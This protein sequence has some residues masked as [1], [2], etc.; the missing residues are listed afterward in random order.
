MMKYFDN[1]NMPVLLGMLA[2]AVAILIAVF[3]LVRHLHK[4]TDGRKTERIVKKYSEAYEREVIFPD[5]IGGYFFID[6]L[7]LLQG[8]IVALNIAQ[9]KGYVF[10]GEN[11]EAWT[12]IENNKSTKFKNPLE[13]VKLFVNHAKDQLKFDGIMARVLFDSKCEFPKGVPEGVSQLAYFK[14][15]MA[16]WAGEAHAA[17]ATN[18]AW[19]TLSALL[20][21]SRERYNKEVGVS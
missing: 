4:T 18:K 2:A 17:E 6:Y 14:K 21:E 1:E 12:L 13:D 8:K 3:L 9:V 7:I 5:G 10:G 11:I 20:A 19:K 15:N 16:A